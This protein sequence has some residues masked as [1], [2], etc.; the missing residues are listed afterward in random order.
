MDAVQTSFDC[1]DLENPMGQTCKDALKINFGKKLKLEFHGTKVTS[2]AGL[3]AYRELDEVLGLTTM[4][5]SEFND[6]RKGKNTQHKNTAL[7]RQSIYSRLAPCPLFL[8]DLSR[9]SC[10]SGRQK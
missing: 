7:L 1:S 2:D 8:V 3:P 6:N 5:E 4:S 9:K 10:Y